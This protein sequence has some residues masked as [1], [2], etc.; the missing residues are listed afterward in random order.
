M[1]MWENEVYNN[2]NANTNNNEIEF[3]LAYFKR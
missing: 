3:S 1:N 2:Q